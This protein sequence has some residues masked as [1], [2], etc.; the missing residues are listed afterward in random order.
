MLQIAPSGY[1]RHLAEQRNPALRCAR[2]LRD[3]ALMPKIQQIWEANMQ[4]YGA[5]VWRQ[6]KREGVHVARCTVERLMKRLGLEGVRRGKVVRTTV[7]D[8]ALPCLR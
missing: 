3:E 4:V 6:L 2:A 1:Q 7:P 8:K 5:Q